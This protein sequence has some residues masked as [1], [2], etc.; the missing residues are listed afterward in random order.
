MDALTEIYLNNVIPSCKEQIQES[1]SILGKQRNKSKGVAKYEIKKTAANEGI[2]LSAAYAQY[3]RRS[4]LPGDVKKEIYFE[5]DL[6]SYKTRKEETDVRFDVRVTTKN[7]TYTRKASDDDIK[8]LQGDP[9]VTSIEK[10]SKTLPDTKSKDGEEER[11]LDKDI[12][13]S[14][15]KTKMESFSNWREDLKEIVNIDNKE[16]KTKRFDVL[17]GK[18]NKIDLNPKLSKANEEVNLLEMKEI[19]ET[20]E[21]FMDFIYNVAEILYNEGYDEHDVLELSE[22]LTRDEY[23]NFLSDLNEMFLTEAR[24]SGRI[25]PVTKTGKSVGSLKGGA[26]TSAI[27][28]LR[29]E[30]QARRDSEASASASKPSGLTAALKSQSATATKPKVKTASAAVQSATP[31]KKRG[32]L[33]RIAGAV[34]KGMERHKKATETAGRLARETGKTLSKAASVGSKASRV[35]AGG[36]A[37]GVKSASSVTRRALMASFSPEEC[38]I[39]ESKMKTE[40]AEPNEKPNPKST[41]PTSSEKEKKNAARRRLIDMQIDW[42]KRR[43]RIPMGHFESYEKNLDEL[44]R[45]EKETG[46]SSGSLN[47]PKGKPTKKGGETD[48]VMRSIRQSMR[49][50]SGRPAGQRPK[51]RGKKPPVAGEYGARRSPE[52]IVKNRRMQRQAAQDFMHSPRD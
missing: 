33:D 25:E 52:Q 48:P 47:M 36:V 40:S 23:I 51:V 46:S 16:D 26:K 42:E 49:K 10:I 39:I 22:S 19:D 8:D 43:G 29:K 20:N 41:Q 34:L 14:S 21:I 45:Y 11:N 6:G 38:E 44:N 12:K 24:R 28:R 30:K 18:D 1:P 35:V 31:K 4:S 13:L 2:P 15:I 9:K 27:N 5:L 50:Q 17:K 32:A 37:S 7:R 3:M